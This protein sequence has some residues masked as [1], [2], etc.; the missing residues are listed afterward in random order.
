MTY[1]IR[2]RPEDGTRESEVVVE[3][4]SPTEALVKFRHTQDRPSRPA[5][6]QRRITSVS[7]ESFG[8]D[9]EW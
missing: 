9:G 6:M 5:A 8:D 4:H 1:R 3:A 7:P 2:Y